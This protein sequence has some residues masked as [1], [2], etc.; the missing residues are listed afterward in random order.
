[1]VVHVLA[2]SRASAVVVLVL[3]VVFCRPPSSS[4]S[5]TMLLSCSH[6]GGGLTSIVVPGCTNV[7]RNADC[8]SDM[9]MLWLLSCAIVSNIMSVI[10]AGVAA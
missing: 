1:M 8:M 9:Y 6:S 7:L 3:R 5:S 4:R 10:A 2:S